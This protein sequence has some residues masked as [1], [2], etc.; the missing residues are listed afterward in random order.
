MS[1]QAWQSWDAGRDRW[2]GVLNE[3]PVPPRAAQQD[4]PTSVPVLARVLWQVDGEELVRT[5]VDA[6]AGG[7]VHIAL[8]DPRRRIAWAWLAAKDVLRVR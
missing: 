8:P 2:Q 6:W 7:D 5:F 3:R 4:L 1:L